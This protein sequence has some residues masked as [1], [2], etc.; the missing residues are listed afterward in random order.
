MAVFL[1]A[2]STSLFLSVLLYIIIHVI[3]IIAEYKCYNAQIVHNTLS[4]S[5]H[6]GG[7]THSTS[8]LEMLFSMARGASFAAE[9]RFLLV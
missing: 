7:G 2:L 8:S 5:W 1:A 9:S 6:E 3:Y 4:M